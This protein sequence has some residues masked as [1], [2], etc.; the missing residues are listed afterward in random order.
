MQ[1]WICKM[2]QMKQDQDTFEIECFKFLL[3]ICNQIMSPIGGTKLQ[4]KRPKV[5]EGLGHVER[6]LEVIPRCIIIII[7]EWSHT[8]PQP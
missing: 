7:L 2:V 1:A 6:S 4:F 8:Y 5:L 3:D